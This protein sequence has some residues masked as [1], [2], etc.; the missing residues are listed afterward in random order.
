MLAKIL[1]Y[2]KGRKW[3][4]NSSMIYKV[5]GETCSL[6]FHDCTEILCLTAVVIPKWWFSNLLFKA[7]LEILLYFLKIFSLYY[8]NSVQFSSVTQLCPTLCDPMNRSVPGL[9]SITNSRSSLTLTFIESVM[10]SSHVILCH[11]LF[12]LLPIPPSIRVFSNESTLRMRMTIYPTYLC[13]DISSK[14][15]TQHSFDKDSLSQG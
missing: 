10:P 11:P 14:L 1:K 9:L 5:R 7:Q 3:D 15:N 12:L 6:F 4:S 13:P 2:A 8:N